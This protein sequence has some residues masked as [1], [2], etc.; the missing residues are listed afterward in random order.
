MF[1]KTGIPQFAVGV[2][3]EPP[4]HTSGW[5]PPLSITPYIEDVGKMYGD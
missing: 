3:A 4:P 2:D 5:K 1:T